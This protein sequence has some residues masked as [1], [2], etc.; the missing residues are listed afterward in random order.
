MRKGRPGWLA[1]CFQETPMKVTQKAAL[2]VAAL[3]AISTVQADVPAES[4]FLDRFKGSWTGSGIIQRNAETSPWRVNCTATGSRGPDSIN[5]NG[6][7][8]AA[9]IIQRPIGAN[10]TVDPRSGDYSGVYTGARVGPA[11]LSGTRNGD[12]VR[13]TIAWPKPVNGDTK[14]EM[15]I[16]NEGSGVLRIV[17]ND[18]LSPGGPVQQT[19][20]LVLRQR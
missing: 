2:A 5:I 10:L 11:R 1:P 9:I 4:A 6:N 16:R 14:A 13:L 18:N 20:E 19:S 7:C 12:V 3:A 8:R 17:V 15:T